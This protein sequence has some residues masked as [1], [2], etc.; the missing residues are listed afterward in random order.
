MQYLFVLFVAAAAFGLCF[1]VDKGFTALFRSKS[2]HKSGKAVRQGKR[3]GSFGLIIGILGLACIFAEISDTWLWYLAGGFL[4]LLGTVMVFYY[5]T[6]GI[7]YDEQTFL[8]ERFG[9]KST[10]YRYVQIQSQ[11]LYNAGGTI[12]VELYL[13]DGQA[14]QLQS[15][16]EGF[17]EFMDTAYARWLEQ[18]GRDPESC[19]FHDRE[20]CCWFP[21]AQEE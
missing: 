18:T 16:M 2:Q 17:L 15:R 19:T 10:V 12:V 5:M 14:L 9:K 6:F 3:Y 11:Q 7:Y 20:K 4:I 21:N 13:S 8:V 1:L